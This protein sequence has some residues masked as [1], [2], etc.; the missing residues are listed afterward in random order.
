MG[1]GPRAHIGQN[2]LDNVGMLSSRD[3]V[4]QLK[5]N[6]V[7]KILHNLSPEYMKIFFLL[8]FLLFIGIVPGV[9]LATLLFLI[10][11]VTLGPLSTIWPFITGTLCQTRSRI[12]RILICSKN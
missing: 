10:Q 7:F 5:L 3:R 12:F 2:E 4:V 9:A 1:A 11:W 8:E 6:H